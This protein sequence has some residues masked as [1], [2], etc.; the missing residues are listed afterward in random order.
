MPKQELPKAPEGMPRS[1]AYEMDD[2]A[3]LLLPGMEQELEYSPDGLSQVG[4][5]SRVIRAGT[6]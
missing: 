1:G 3:S 5:A 4:A 6:Q 2:L